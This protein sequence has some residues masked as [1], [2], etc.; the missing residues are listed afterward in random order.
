VA[1]AQVTSIADN[2]S[3]NQRCFAV[4][5]LMSD[6]VFNSVYY[7]FHKSNLLSLMKIVIL[8]QLSEK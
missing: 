1:A 7:R 4:K 6:E 3:T 2:Y 5:D 8:L